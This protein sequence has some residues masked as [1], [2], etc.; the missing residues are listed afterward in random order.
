MP[1]YGSIVERLSW[2]SLDLIINPFLSISL[3]SRYLKDRNMI[4]RAY[5]CVRGLTTHS[6]SR[7]PKIYSGVSWQIVLL[8]PFDK[9]FCVIHWNSLFIGFCQ[10]DIIDIPAVAEGGSACPVCRPWSQW[11]SADC[12][13]RRRCTLPPA[14]RCCHRRSCD[15]TP[16]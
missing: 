14:Y 9:C 15:R 11:W 4:Y 13:R 12:P 16:P 5:M 8:S 1:K 3:S 6:A 2:F 7:M 10:L